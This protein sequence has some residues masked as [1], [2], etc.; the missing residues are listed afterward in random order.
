MLFV[1]NVS[2]D[3]NLNGGFLGM[4][5]GTVAALDRVS[6]EVGERETFAL[7]GES[8]SGKTTLARIIAGLTPATAGEGFS[9]RLERLRSVR[10]CRSFFRIPMPA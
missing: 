9:R 2:K 7:I 5:S 6:L 3:F 1:K 8:G 10:M 4:R